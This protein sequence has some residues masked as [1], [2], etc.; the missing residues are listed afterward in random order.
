MPRRTKCY[1]FPTTDKSALELRAHVSAYIGYPLYRLG[2]G[3]TG[4]FS[5]PRET[6]PTK[7]NMKRAKYALPTVSC[8]IDYGNKARY[9]K[10]QETSLGR[11]YLPPCHETILVQFQTTCIPLTSGDT[12]NVES[13]PRNTKFPMQL[14]C[15]TQP[16]PPAPY[17]RG[18]AAYTTLPYNCCTLAV[19]PI[20]TPPSPLPP[21]PRKGC[22]IND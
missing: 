10:P 9:R 14:P 16:P 2:G 1:M 15:S 3:I 21:S 8:R 4:H 7:T 11:L 20:I 13:I 6:I 5:H 22:V 12:G 18:T 17:N 19:Q